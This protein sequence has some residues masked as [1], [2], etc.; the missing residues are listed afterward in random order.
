MKKQRNYFQLK[1]QDKC[2]E[3]TNNE[4]D[5]STQPGPE[6]KKEVIKMLK[7]LRMTISRN[8]DYCNKEQETIKRSQSKLDIPIAKMKTE[9]KAI[10]SKLNNTEK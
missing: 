7:E 8:V 6:F 2:P 9:L 3:R 4:T 5:L 1:E 10:K